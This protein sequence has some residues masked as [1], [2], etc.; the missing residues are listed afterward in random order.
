V[1]VALAAA[2]TGFTVPEALHATQPVEASGKRRDDVRLL[3]ARPGD[4]EHVRFRD[5]GDHLTP[6]DLLVV[7]TSA[8]L[9][10]AVD[11]I[12]P[13]GAPATVHFS[14]PGAG[15]RW[16]V[17]LRGADGSRRSSAPGEL[18][19]LPGG[20]RMQIVSANRGDRL[21][22]A[23]FSGQ[24]TVERYLA[25]YGRPI[26]YDY[27]HDRWPLDAYQTIFARN[28]GS[29]EMPSAARPFTSR[30][31]TDLVA[32]GVTIAPVVL[33]CGVSSLEAGELPQEERYE[34][35]PATARLVNETRR[36]GARVIATGTTAARALESVARRDGTV[37]PG[38][39]VTE[40]VLSAARPARVIDGLVTGWHPP[41]ASHLSLLEAVAGL[42]LVQE[43]YD[44]AVAHE[45]LWHE[46]GDS[47]LLLPE[48]RDAAVREAA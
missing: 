29:A 1:N 39:G 47:C 40:L 45:Y 17:E 13:D 22:S 18:V 27:V 8:T 25:R 24:D 28:P 2:S 36:S 35:P 21:W 32:R 37:V 12:H 26:T 14:S 31:V 16:I 43:A 23:R 20:V 5:I 44:R 4:F 6:G 46:F 41:G 38:A 19:Y 34:V 7:N 33:H 42:E 48:P 15:G 3:V 30:L 9:A 11:G 10:A